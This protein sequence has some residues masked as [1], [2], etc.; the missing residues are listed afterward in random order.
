MHTL[1]ISSNSLIEVTPQDFSPLCSLKTIAINDTRI[2]LCRC[3]QVTEYMATHKVFMKEGINC[4][5]LPPLT[6]E[7]VFCTDFKNETKDSTAYTECI[8]LVKTKKLNQEA[9]ITWMT[10]AAVL[11]GFF[12]VLMGVLYIFHRRSIR[13]AK[14]MQEIRK[15]KKIHSG[16]FGNTDILLVE[17]KL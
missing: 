13:K 5:N 11:V 17:E 6:E 9:K 2:P 7:Y 4:D 14:E 8:S 12:I 1:N 16:E 10:I 3:H 15:L